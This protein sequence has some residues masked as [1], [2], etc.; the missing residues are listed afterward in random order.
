MP[1]IVDQRGLMSVSCQSLLPVDRSAGA[2]AQSD[3]DLVV[4][5]G[6]SIGFDEHGLTHRTFHSKSAPIHAGNNIFDDD[7]SAAIER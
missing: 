4:P 1:A 5:I 2:V 7:A 6:K 3:A